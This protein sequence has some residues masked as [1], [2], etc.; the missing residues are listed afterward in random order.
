MPGGLP[1]D[2]I[3]FGMVAAFLVLRLRGVLGRRTG[4]ERPA[5]PE[6][7]PAAFGLRPAR[8]AE[9][10]SG[11]GADRAL[12]DPRSPPG[13]ALAR[14][15]AAD[16]GFAP[17]PFLDGAETA[18]RMIVSAFAAGDRPTLR[19]LLSDDTYAG[20]E[21]A[22]AAREAAGET[23]RTEIRAVTQV[24]IEAAD[25]RGRTADITLRFVSDQ[26]NLRSD[27]AGAIVL[28]SDA[29]TEIVDLWTF[30]R[31]LA[32]NDPTWRLVATANP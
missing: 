25:L 8:P 23:Q 32:T 28:G 29:V 31:D 24:S 22:I 12:P 4:F 17:G 15:G 1:V 30:Q 19:A 5:Q 26:V 6:P 27:A 7:R 16:R 9:E 18:F 21:Q 13:Q 14:I 2:L 10:T 11:A 3:L 20:F